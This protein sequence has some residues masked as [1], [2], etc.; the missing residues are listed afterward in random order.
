[1]GGWHWASL[2][3]HENIILFYYVSTLSCK[4]YWTVSNCPAFTRI[5]WSPHVA[6]CLP[7]W[8]ELVSWVSQPLDKERRSKATVLGSPSKGKKL[9]FLL[10]HCLLT[11]RSI[12]EGLTPN[13]I[14]TV[15]LAIPLLGVAALSASA[16]STCDNMSLGPRYMQGLSCPPGLPCDM[17]MRCCFVVE[18]SVLALEFELDGSTAKYSGSA[19][20]SRGPLE[21]RTCV[22]EHLASRA[23]RLSSGVLRR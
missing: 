11:A 7:Q 16:R 1:M 12:V 5:D 3:Q 10:N 14:A 17:T 15:T 22:M 6:A 19:D 4:Q 2:I 9:R 8:K 18:A 20:W 13:F 21:A 23:S